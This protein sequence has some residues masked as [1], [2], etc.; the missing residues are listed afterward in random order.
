MGLFK[1]KKAED[2]IA[3]RE[4]MA[5]KIAAHRL[6][7][8]AERE[9]ETDIIIGRDGGFSIRNGEFIVF[10]DNNVVFRCLVTE[11]Q[12]SEFLSLEGAIIT[13]PDLEHGG[14]VRTILAYYVYFR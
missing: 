13:A 10:A 5:K 9:G 6:R 11:M 4:K 7:Y 1:K 2:S 3:F 8:V 14:V 12:A